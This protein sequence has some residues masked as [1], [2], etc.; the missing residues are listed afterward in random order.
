[1]AKKKLLVLIGIALFAFILLNINIGKLL[2]ILANANPAFF[3]IALAL[4]LLTG[5]MKGVKWREVIRAHDSDFPLRKCIKVFFIGY[6]ISV[7][8]PARIG[9]FARAFYLQKNTKSLGK[10]LSTVF[11]DRL[12]DVSLLFVLGLLA[13][14]GFALLFDIVVI[15][16]HYLALIVLAFI[17]AVFLFLRRNFIGRIAKPFYNMF[18]PMEHKEKLKTSFHDFYDSFAHAIKKGKIHISRAVAIAVFDW[19]L[20][21]VFAYMLIIALNL[22]AQIPII[23]LFLLVPIAAL[24]DL[25]P[26]SISGIGTRDAAFLFLFGF[27]SIVPEMAIAYS[28]L[29]LF[30]GYWFSALIGALLFSTEP[31]KLG[32]SE[33]NE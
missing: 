28:L 13:I 16:L 26:I 32:L 6:F 30:A 3:A 25:L 15:P 10:A 17:A 9:D 31:V 4:A 5:F 20:A 27:Y 23:F 1:M 14:A 18:V 8:T 19:L 2:G 7:F 33:S 22:H 24:L 29:Y 12:I 11:I 21:I